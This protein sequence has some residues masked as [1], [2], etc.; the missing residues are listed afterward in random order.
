MSI[1]TTKRTALKGAA[2]FVVVFLL[3]LNRLL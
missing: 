1:Q 2:L 3:G